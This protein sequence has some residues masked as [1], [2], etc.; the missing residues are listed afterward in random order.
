MIG[1]SFVATQ[2]I[3]VGL[4]SAAVVLFSTS[5]RAQETGTQQ[6]PLEAAEIE[7]LAAKQKHRNDV[8]EKLRRGES[9]K[10]QPQPHT[11]SINDYPRG[12]FE[13]LPRNRI[14]WGALSWFEFMPKENRPFAFVRS[15][16][17]RIPPRNFFT[18]GGSIPRLF[19]SSL[20]R[21]ARG[22]PTILSPQRS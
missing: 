1:V 22:C 6:P 3:L 4:L 14:Q 21:R 10:K 13:N 9:V 18:D 17:E 12:R 16:G 8:I 20:D 11:R 19:K 5:S 2:H 7:A 15:T